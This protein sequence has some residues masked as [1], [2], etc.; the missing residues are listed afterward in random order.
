MRMKSL[1]LLLALAACQSTVPQ[2]DEAAGA[3]IQ[4]RL[5][6]TIA[7][8][9]ILVQEVL[10]EAPVRDV[11]AAY[12]TEA[13]WRAWA[14]PAV[15]IDLRAGGLIQTH[16]GQGAEIGDPGTNTIHILNYVPE[17]VLTLRADVEERWPKVM[18]EDADHLMNVIVFE[19][20]GAGRTKI[21]S[22]GVGYRD[23]VA[24]NE[25]MGFFVPANEGLF[26]VLKD[27]LE[28]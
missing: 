6:K 2:V 19:A 24:Y 26:Q 20:L 18:Q 21:L 3:E 16:Y 17:R 1:V 8:D 5:V 28:K 27:Y 13:G 11:W 15:K 7:G 23:S 10:I 14:S 12:T 9:L 22:Y 4:S 25:L